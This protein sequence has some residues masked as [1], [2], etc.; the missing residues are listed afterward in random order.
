MGDCMKI[1]HMCKF[2]EPIRQIVLRMDHP[3][4]FILEQNGFYYDSVPFPVFDSIDKYLC[5]R[6][7]LFNSFSTDSLVTSKT[8]WCIKA[9]SCSKFPS[10]VDSDIPAHKCSDRIHWNCRE[11]GVMWND[12][13][14]QE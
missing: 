3:K 8:T 9:T 14:S 1:K 10:Y 12:V 11:Q 7:Y 13:V 5:E 2:E 6:N 4:V